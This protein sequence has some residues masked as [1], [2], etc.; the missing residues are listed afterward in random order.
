MLY[1][2]GNTIRLT[3]GDTA[4]LTFPMTTL[5]GEEYV[6]QKG[7][8]LRFTVRKFIDDENFMLQ[9]V[10]TGGNLIHIEPGDTAGLA[11]GLYKYDVELTTSSGDVFTIIDTST[12][13]ILSEVTY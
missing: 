8:T 1:I 2:E 6:V 7:D 12:F 5:E 11:F 4:Y 9:K 10:I 13:E 3:R